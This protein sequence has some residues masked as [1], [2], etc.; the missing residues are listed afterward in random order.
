MDMDKREV[1]VCVFVCM[2]I[3]TESFPEWKARQL[4]MYGDLM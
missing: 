1:C 4:N 3:G 2:R